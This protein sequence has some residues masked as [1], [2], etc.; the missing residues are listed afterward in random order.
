MHSMSALFEDVSYAVRT[1][2]RSPGFVL[3][4]VA[5]LA[6]GI[7]AN[8]AVF[9]V[10]D[11]VLV[12]PLPYP[13][14]DRIVTVEETAPGG[15]LEAVS[16]PN[17]LD[18]RRQAR[19]FESL[20][21]YRREGVN[22]LAP[23]GP[24]R[25]QSASVSEG[26]VSS[27]FGVRPLLGRGFVPADFEAAAPPVA[28]ISERLWRIAFGA[29]PKVVGTA[30]SLGGR[31]PVVA[32]I[33]PKAFR[34]PPH[35]DLW[36]PLLFDASF[37]ETRG[38]HFLATVGRLAPGATLASAQAEMRVVARRLEQLHPGSNTG[39]GA[40]VALLG[41]RM[42]RGL[43]PALLV[44]LGAV[45]CVLLIACANVASLLLARAATRGREMAIRS[46]V[47]AGRPRLVRQLLTE[48]LV[49]FA[50]GGGVGLLLARS[51]IDIL[52][53][54]APAGPLESFP[55]VRVNAAVAAAALALTVLA[56][57]AAGLAP[58]L[59]ASRLAGLAPQLRVSGS[60]AAGPRS[61]RT[62]RA[63]VAT[64]VALAAVLLVCGGLMLR[65]LA[66]LRSVDPGFDPS[67]VLTADLHLPLLGAA[68]V[69][70]RRAA[71]SRLVGRVEALP[72]V[73]SASL[74]LFPPMSGQSDTG[75]VRVEG[76]P[77]P[78]PGRENVVGQRMVAPRYFATLGI[79]IVEGRDFTA[80][81]DER[82]PGVAIV[83]LVMAR[84]FWPGQDPIGR[85]I[86]FDVVEGKPTWLPVV[87]VVG[88]VRELG[89]DEEPPPEVYVPYL[90]VAPEVIA[91]F[92]PKEPLSLVVRAAVAPLSLV[93]SVRRAV[94]EA[95][96]DL[97]VT[98]IRPLNALVSDA[99]A[100][101]RVE[102][103]VLGAF[104]G[105]AL[106]LAALGVG[107]VVAFAVARRSREMSV[108]AAL[109]ATP[110]A[111]VA[112]TL[113]ET[114]SPVGLGLAAGLAAA[115]GASRLLSG[116]LYGV[117]PADPST[118]AAVGVLLAGVAGLAA[119]LPAR[120]VARVDPVVAMRA[121]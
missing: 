62:R 31:S 84:R 107:G 61:D 19:S 15:D 29:D 52:L 6:L 96:P 14:P 28:L 70:G 113:K 49:L 33:L 69:A 9:S 7:G 25:L 99:V 12:R 5:I 16:G 95:T 50:I 105:L 36:T 34:Y 35:C 77:A 103:F 27:V 59:S 26:F 109:G 120:R 110:L 100:D 86:A 42:A 57:V 73:T 88:D 112:G 56:S 41:E 44:L 81:D 93:D 38:S 1:L 118:Y 74:V 102:F 82:A 106:A 78:A 71:L 32:G 76:A 48:T 24:R 23:D 83:N 89:P 87:G 63:I 40:R 72:G 60:G 79:P 39:R 91:F 17:F 75:N 94:R 66:S 21:A 117:S 119:W 55:A 20:A 67:H 3:T 101:R 108:R 114:L 111:L 53:S 58:A 11:A 45:A 98:G 43:R 2:R 65:T 8:T 90:Q 54:L 85:R 68:D 13:A 97:P 116:L 115:L 30:L 104:G 4:A 10:V 37:L 64:E 47:G 51:G 121:E 22:L 46:A 18:W 80:A 92:G